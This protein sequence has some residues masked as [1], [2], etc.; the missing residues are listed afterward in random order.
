MIPT[1]SSDSPVEFL[2]E[3][4]RQER[5]EAGV[6]QALAQLSD[7]EQFILSRRFRLDGSEQPT[8][9]AECGRILKLT[10]E[11]VR[12][13]EARALRR[14]SYRARDVA[15]ETLDLKRCPRCQRHVLTLRFDESQDRSVCRS[16]FNAS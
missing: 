10:T 16:C 1:R 13:L 15:V 4:E 9:L 2:M 7:R 3:Q 6:A 14:L 8:T 5:M 12:Q 11:R